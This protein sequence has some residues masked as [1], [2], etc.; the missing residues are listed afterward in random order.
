MFVI[1]KTTID[2]M[3][4]F[5]LDEGVIIEECGTCVSISVSKLWPFKSSQA[6]CLSAIHAPF[7]LPSRSTME[8]LM[9]RLAE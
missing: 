6:V 5:H 2:V 7:Q 1:C 3:C 8:L 9:T 4:S